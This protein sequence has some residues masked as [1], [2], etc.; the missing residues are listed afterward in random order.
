GN[1]GPTVWWDGRIVGGWAQRPEGEVVVRL[2]DDVGDEARH[3]IDGEVERLQRW[4]GGVRVMPRF[5]TP[6]QKEL[7]GS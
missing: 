3:A 5:P 7:A 6:L 1:A 2:L 4:L